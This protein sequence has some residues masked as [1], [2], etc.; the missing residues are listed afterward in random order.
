MIK[1][2]Y[3]TETFIYMKYHSNNIIIYVLLLKIKFCVL[4]IKCMI[5]IISTDQTP[6]DIRR[7][8]RRV[9]RPPFYVVFLPPPPPQSPE[10]SPT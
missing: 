5:Y 9:K 3:A 7:R 8:K 10:P 6:K 1:R 4:Y 2:D